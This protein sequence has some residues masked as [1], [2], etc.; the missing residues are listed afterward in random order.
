MQIKNWKKSNEDDL[1]TQNIKQHFEDFK[2]EE[3]E[4]H[5]FKTKKNNKN[6]KKNKKN[7][8]YYDKNYY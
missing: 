6:T 4:E 1:L 8:N 5:I 7:K 3:K 2:K